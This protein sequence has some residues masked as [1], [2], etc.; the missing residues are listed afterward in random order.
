MKLKL[1]GFT[2]LTTVI[3]AIV[4]YLMVSKLYFDADS[5]GLTIRYEDPVDFDFDQ[6]KER[7]VIR[8]ATRYSSVSYFLH[9]GLERGFE[10]DFFS[11]FARAHNLRV[12][13]VIPTENED[14]IDLLNRGDADIIAQ[15]YSITPNRARYI[16]FSEPYNL[17]NQVVVLPPHMIDSVPVVDSLAGMRV[18]VRR[19]SSYY[20][21][22]RALQQRGIAV[23]IH[24]VSDQ[25]DTE[26][27]LLGV[28]N[29]DFEATIADDN[30]YGAASVYIKGIAQGPTLANRDIIA[31]GLRRNA[32]ELKQVVD[33][34]LTSHFRVREDD[35]EPRRSALLN[36]LRERYFENEAMI[37]RFRA[38]VPVTEYSGL[39][40]PYDELVR[41]IAEEMGVDW[42][43]VVAIM[44]QESRFD[45][46]AISWAGAVGLMQVLPRFSPLT[47][48]E[49]FDEET[50]IREGIRIISKHLRHYAYLDSTNQIALALATYNAGMGHVADARRIAIDSNRDPNN[51]EAVE[52]GLLKLMNRQY[53]QHARYGFCRGIET[54]N[55][56]RDIMNRYR[57]Y[58]T[59]V[60]LATTQEEVRTRTWTI[61]YSGF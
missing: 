50:S 43:L 11:E 54:S 48:E 46:N 44:A 41:P 21:S 51:W 55:Y 4:A 58:D 8:L 36:I 56:V 23:E 39:L 24:I 12:E 57:T 59:I 15:N 37:Q 7:G 52:D 38:P 29:G 10:F 35:G 3:I 60:T 26:A 32:P 31:W 22:L 9:H 17:V 53:Y 6:I 25:W 20:Q 30:L 5:Y 28:A 2:T 42:K 14:P 47:E 27:I 40:S 61:G 16:E 1:Y 33:E 49:L 45:P 19:N 13:V 34:Y 18:T